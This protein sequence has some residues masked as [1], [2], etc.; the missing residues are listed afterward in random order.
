MFMHVKL[1]KVYFQELQKN[2]TQTTNLLYMCIR[3]VKKNWENAKKKYLQIWIPVKITFWQSNSK[4]AIKINEKKQI[5]Q[6][7]DFKK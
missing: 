5:V 1:S 4:P 7:I 2:Q 6:Y 3:K